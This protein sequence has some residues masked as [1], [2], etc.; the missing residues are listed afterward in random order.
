M[1][2]FELH[3]THSYP[4][5]YKIDP[6]AGLEML[7]FTDIWCLEMVLFTESYC[8]EMLRFTKRE[9]ADM[10]IILEIPDEFDNGQRSPFQ[11][12]TVFS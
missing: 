6:T 8:L 4:F 3:T 9:T 11:Y 2:R 5:D 7:R 10:S 12:W 1:Q